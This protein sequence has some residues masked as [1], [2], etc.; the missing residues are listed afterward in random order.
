VKHASC[1]RAKRVSCQCRNHG[2]CPWC[3]RSRTMNSL[4]KISGYEQRLRE[5]TQK[6]APRD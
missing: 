5:W 4:R 1:D 3:R 6:Q 2:T